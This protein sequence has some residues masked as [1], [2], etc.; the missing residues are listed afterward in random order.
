MHSNSN[1]M[2]AIRLTG[3]QRGLSLIVTLVITAGVGLIVGS[4]LYLTSVRAVLTRRIGQFDGSVAAAVAA[5][6][7]VHGRMSRDFQLAGEDAVAGN[8]SNYR[9]LVPLTAQV[10]WKNYEFADVSGQNN[11]T[12]VQKLSDWG[13]RELHTRFL[14]LQ[15]YAADYKIISQ[16]R[17]LNSPYD[18]VA[19]V[20]QQVQVASIPIFQYQLFYVPDMEI[21]PSGVGMTFN[22]RVH[23]NANAYCKPEGTVT[24]LNHVTIARRFH[25]ARHPDDPVATR[26]GQTVFRAERATSVNTLNIPIGTAST[27][28][29]LHALIDPPPMGELPVSLLGQQRF[30]N[31]ADLIVLVNHGQISAL[32]GIYNGSS[33]TIPWIRR[34]VTVTA[35]PVYDKRECRD[36]EMIEIE[37]NKLNENM[38]DLTAV[39]GRTVKVIWIADVSVPATMRP[40]AVRLRNADKLPGTGLTIATPQPLYVVGD[41]NTPPIVP[42]CLAADAVTVL[43]KNWQDQDAAKGLPVRTAVDTTIN[44]AV[45]TG[46]VPTRPGWYSGGV[47]NALRLLENWSGKTLTFHGALAVLYHSGRAT[48]P[49]GGPDVYSPPIRKFSYDWNLSQAARLPPGTP[50]VRTIL[51][52]DWMVVQACIP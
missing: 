51:H 15:G 21:H 37:L 29:M 50:E 43:S 25:H 44:A 4:V 16:T 32:S 14:G 47:E 39:L 19:A 24:F 12:T 9:S 46:I 1:A 13:F 6:Q 38:A 42:A 45:I 34:I 7:K 2:S 52:S 36:L 30:Y 28:T 22:G 3:G 35:R 49:W 11:Q 23:C 18:I 31:K 48:A 33:V 20:E 40:R 5:T 26:S 8:L 41:F 17:R 10:P 27:A